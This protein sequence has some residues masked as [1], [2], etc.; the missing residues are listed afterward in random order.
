[1]AISGTYYIYVL[2]YINYVTFQNFGHK[3][4][5]AKITFLK[6]FAAVASICKLFFN[7]V[8]KAIMVLYCYLAWCYSINLMTYSSQYG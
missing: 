7:W 3:E 4:S 1:M 5:N 2:F 6:E 8:Y